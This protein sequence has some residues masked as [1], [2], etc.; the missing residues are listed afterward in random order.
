MTPVTRSIPERLLNTALRRGRKAT[1]ALP[2]LRRLAGGDIVLTESALNRVL[3]HAGL[4]EELPL[5]WETL[6]IRL[7]DGYFEFDV[8]GAVKFIHGPVFRLQ[9]RFESVEISLSRQ[10]V[11]VRLLREI[12]T[13]AHGLTERVLMLLVRAI[14]GPLLAPEGLFKAMDRSHDAFVQEE[15]DLIRMELH[16]LEPVRKHMG[17]NLL[18]AA[19]AII[20]KDTVLIRAIDCNDGEMVIRTTTVARE[21]SRKAIKL[22]VV[23]GSVAGR[24]MGVLQEVGRQVAEDVRTLADAAQD[25][26]DQSEDSHKRDDLR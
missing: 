4:D 5:H 10:I 18:G 15:P 24:A 16:R 20:G 8:Q 21:L 3:K 12:Q 19:G 23:A 13:F 9:A 22:G 1:K 7:R 25:D 2:L 17:G 14:F 11:R 6:H 26:E